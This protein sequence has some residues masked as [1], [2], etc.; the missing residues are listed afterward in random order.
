MSMSLKKLE[1]NLEDLE[2]EIETVEPSMAHGK[3]LDD[4]GNVI[5]TF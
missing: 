5:G 4:Y 3:I 1:I 2:S